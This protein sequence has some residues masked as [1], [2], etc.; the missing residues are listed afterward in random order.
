MLGILAK[1]CACFLITCVDSVELYSECCI[2]C[3]CIYFLFSEDNS[4]L[5]LIL[6]WQHLFYLDI[7]SHF[8]PKVLSETEKNNDIY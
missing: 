8:Y 5:L 3:G 2:C 7:L 1:F 4:K 6:F